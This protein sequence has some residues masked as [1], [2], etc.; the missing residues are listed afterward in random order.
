[1]GRFSGFTE[2]Y[3]FNKIV[4]II[5]FSLNSNFGKHGLHIIFGLFFVDNNTNEKNLKKF[6]F[7]YE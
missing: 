2:T 7:S 4:S 3:K 5:I 6:I 1:M